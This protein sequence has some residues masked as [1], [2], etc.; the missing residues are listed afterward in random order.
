MRRPKRQGAG[1]AVLPL[2]L[3]VSL[4]LNMVPTSAIAEAMG[5][6]TGATEEQTEVEAEASEVSLEDLQV[7]L[8]EAVARAEEL[9]A[10][11]EE[12]SASAVQVDETASDLTYI[13]DENDYWNGYYYTSVGATGEA[14]ADTGRAPGVYVELDDEGN[15][16]IA[17]ACGTV[18]AYE[19]PA[20]LDGHPVVAIGGGA[21]GTSASGPGRDGSSVLLPAFV[22]C[23]LHLEEIGSGAFGTTS[24]ESVALPDSVKTIAQDAFYYCP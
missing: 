5:V 13:D 23:W 20:E 16:T 18:T 22:C 10:E 7:Q 4:M 14:D 3:V 15:A 8:E 2:L 17:K 12:G 1:E 21:F 6:D 11:D 24:I 19:V 9:S